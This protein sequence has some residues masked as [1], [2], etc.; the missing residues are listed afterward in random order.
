[1]SEYD[2]FWS[3]VHKDDEAE[4]GRIQQLGRDIADQFE[5]LTGEK[6]NLFLDREDIAWGENWRAKIDSGLASV[7]FFIPVLTPRYFQSPECRR[8]LH[9]FATKAKNLGVSE[10]V[11]PLLYVNVA[12]LT[13]GNPEDELMK[14]V[15]KFQRQNWT[16]LS[17]AGR[18]SSD[19]RRAVREL[20]Q[21]LVN[22]NLTAEAQIGQKVEAPLVGTIL[23]QPDAEVSETDSEDKPGTLELLVGLQ[24][25]LPKIKIIME[26]VTVEIQ[27][28]GT[29]TEEENTQIQYADK[30][31]EGAVGRARIAKSM[32][33]KINGP[34]L[35]LRT[36]GNNYTAE[37]HRV[38]EGLRAQLQLFEQQKTYSA[39][40]IKNA[41][42]VHKSLQTLSQAGKSTVISLENFLTA[43]EE[44]EQFSRDLRR[45]LRIIR[46]GLTHV[47]EGQSIIDDWGVISKNALPNVKAK[48][49]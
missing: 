11:L 43:S 32:A 49:T 13:S 3:Y 47:I 14:L 38:N 1:M 42:E 44:L 45:P 33:Q 12:E 39:K 16:E 4:G 10:L 18:A 9:Q 28:I 21:K 26:E 40:D 34:A 23:P 48:E 22:A 19:Y 30:R 15:D 31:G 46:Q 41:E 8:E 6:L 17:V 36:L 7:A 27:E 20:A 29:I 35:K 37:L 24:L 25:G 5:L 2:G